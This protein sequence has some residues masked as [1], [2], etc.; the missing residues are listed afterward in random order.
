MT[1]SYLDHFRQRVLQDAL[2]AATANQ[3]TKRA[4]TFAWAAPRPGDFNGRA[5]EAE[6]TERQRRCL[7]TAEACR[8]HAQLLLRDSDGLIEPLVAEVLAE[9]A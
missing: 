3:W 7:E 9:V 2:T 6:L 8:E 4:E 1:V 5:T